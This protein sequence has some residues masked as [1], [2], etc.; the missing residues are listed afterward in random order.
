MIQ[1]LH[2]GLHVH[3]LS[4]RGG[5]GV[6]GVIWTFRSCTAPAQSTETDESPPAELAGEDNDYCDE[7]GWD[8]RGEGV[9]G[10]KESSLGPI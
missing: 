3:S 5:G 9:P 1:S 4:V 2:H 6:L 10:A 8:S 7:K